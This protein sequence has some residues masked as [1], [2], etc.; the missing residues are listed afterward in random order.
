M[1]MKIRSVPKRRTFRQF[2]K[3]GVRGER[4]VETS[5]VSAKTTV[6]QRTPPARGPPGRPSQGASGAPVG[7]ARH[8]QERNITIIRHT[9]A[10][11]SHKYDEA[12]AVEHMPE[13]CGGIRCDRRLWMPRAE[14]LPLSAREKHNSFCERVMMPERDRI[15]M[16]DDLCR[17]A[18]L[19]AQG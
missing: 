11:D 6:G 9:F 18:V 4:H 10:T 16:A 19:Q 15:V 12:L 14:R 8:R 5:T 3:F 1:T 17:N 2:L 7:T 13:P